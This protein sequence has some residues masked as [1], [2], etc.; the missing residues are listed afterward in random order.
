MP[1][2]RT[3]TPDSVCQVV[4]RI[5]EPLRYRREVARTSSTASEKHPARSPPRR[6]PNTGSESIRGRHSQSMDPADEHNAAVR[7]SP[8]SA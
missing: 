6:R 4:S 2:V 5:V 8:M 1:S 7:V 3:T